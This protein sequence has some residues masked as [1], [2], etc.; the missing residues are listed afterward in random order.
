MKSATNEPPRFYLISLGCPKN[1]VDSVGMTILLERAGYRLAED[2]SDADVLIVNTCG[3]IEPARA[4][5]REVL[6]ELVQLKREVTRPLERIAVVGCWVELEGESLKTRFPEVDLW[7]GL[8]T[9]GRIRRLITWIE[10][11]GTSVIGGP[12]YEPPCYEGGRPRIGLPHV[13]YLRVCDGCVNRCSYCTIPSIRGPL[14]SKPTDVVLRE[15][16]A[17]ARQGV[18]ELILIAQDPVSYTHL[19]LPNRRAHRSSSGDVV[20]PGPAHDVHRRLS[21]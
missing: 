15:A 16:E 13:A 7:T 2:V 5:C 8:L 20:R 3:F 18:R 11:G 12:S 9:P 14:R 6:K 21:R 10:R 4:E 19:T 1:L 17:F